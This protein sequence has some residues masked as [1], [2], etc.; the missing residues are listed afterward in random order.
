MTDLFSQFN[1]LTPEERLILE[2]IAIPKV[3]SKNDMVIR[4]GAFNRNFFYLKSGIINGYIIDDNGNENTVFLIDDNLFFGAPDC[5][6][7][8][9]PTDF[10]F[11][12]LVDTEV[13]IFNIGQLEKYSVSHKGIFHFYNTVFKILLQVLVQ[14]VED[15]TRFSPEARYS[16]LHKTRPGLLENA[17]QKQLASFLGFTPN[18]LSRIKKRQ[19]EILNGEDTERKE[20]E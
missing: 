11:Q 19:K 16:N 12:A 15:F 9:V 2:G 14:R 5:I 4:S 3:Y 17:P 8:N 7:Q 13:I 1:D 10:F 6:L 20:E 18:S